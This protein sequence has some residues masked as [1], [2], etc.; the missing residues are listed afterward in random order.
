MIATIEIK[1]IFS[2]ERLHQVSMRVHSKRIVMQ[3]DDLESSLSNLLQN[4]KNTAHEKSCDQSIHQTETI[5]S[6]IIS[7]LFH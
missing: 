1:E 3:P 7:L 6:P 2:E 4:L 5:D